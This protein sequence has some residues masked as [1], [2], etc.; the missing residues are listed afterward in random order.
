MPAAVVIDPQIAALLVPHAAEE[1]A[2]LARSILD[3]GCREPLVV[4]RGTGVLLDGHARHR[5]CVALDICP[6]VRPVELT[7]RQ[8]AVLARS[9]LAE[10]CR[11][12]LTVW[13]PEPHPPAVFSFRRRPGGDLRSQ[14]R[15]RGPTR[16]L[17]ALSMPR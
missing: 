12:P 4:W 10:G 6:E 16:Y 7:D 5:V 8:A 17:A 13:S 14:V 3:E 2:L 1:L 9:I 11:E 15:K